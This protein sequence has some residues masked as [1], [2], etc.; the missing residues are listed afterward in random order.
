MKIKTNKRWFSRGISATATAVV[1]FAVVMYGSQSAL[2]ATYTYDFDADTL[3]LPAANTQAV[4]GSSI[5]ENDPTL[6]QSIS[7]ATR[8][9]VPGG[10]IASVTRFSNVPYT[11][12]DTQITSRSTMTNT[13]NVWGFGL[14]QNAQQEGYYIVFYGSTVAVPPAYHNTA[15]LFSILN[16]RLTILQYANWTQDADHYYRVTATG[17]TITLEESAD[18]GTYNQLFNYTDALNTHPSGTVVYTDAWGSSS[19]N[20]I[21]TDDIVIDTTEQEV[22]IESPR[23]Y[24]V[25]QRDGS[26]QADIVIEGYYTGAPS[27]IEA[28]WNGGPWTTIDAS[29]S[30]EQFSGTLSGQSTGQ[31]AL[32]VR[33]VGSGTSETVQ[34][35]GI[36]DVYAVAGQ[37]NASGYSLPIQSSASN[38]LVAGQYSN[39]DVWTELAANTDSNYQQR[40][41]VSSEAATGAVWD[42]VGTHIMESEN[43]PVAF[44]PT[45]LGGSNITQ[46]EPNDARTTLYGSM[47][48][49]INEAGG[50]KAVLWWQGASN[51]LDGTSKSDYKQMLNDL[52]DAI[53]T[54]FDAPMV[55][56]MTGEYQY[57]NATW[58]EN[59]D[60][61]R[62][63]QYESWEESAN[64]LPGAT[65]YDVDFG[66]EGGDGAHYRSESDVRTLAERWWLAIEDNFYGSVVARGPIMTELEQTTDGTQILINYDKDLGGAIGTTY[67]VTA[68]TVRDSSDV[69]QAIANAEKTGTRQVT[70]TLASP[71]SEAATVWF[72]RADTANGKVTPRGITSASLPAELFYAQ[73]AQI[74]STEPEVDEETGNP[75]VIPAAPDTGSTTNSVIL[76]ATVA[77][78]AFTG[79][80]VA[81]RQALLGQHKY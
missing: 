64:T 48:R 74:L 47:E 33:A 40:D 45:S 29:P 11:T 31:G 16:E 2:A 12:T 67:D 22:T 51:V 77:L 81:M 62:Q 70:L 5:V 24:Q 63:A 23:N 3:G 54:D 27:A 53:R 66:D 57:G 20:A 56:T 8:G 61:I 34:Y 44:I 41:T 1:L 55:I 75:T 13:N 19:L 78:A 58:Q 73:A 39:G 72:G 80:I 50:V 25:L 52:A 15:I 35:V 46:W 79:A 42:V 43:I 6:G 9:S 18:G 4:A 10:Y 21:R 7:A 14:R 68:F 37:S 49:R 69:D 36:G 17:A 60:I 26:E 38:G 76:Y 59:I 65:T 28:R 30:N 32:E 71:L